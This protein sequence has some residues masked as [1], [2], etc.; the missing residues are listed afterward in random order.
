[1]HHRRWRITGI[2]LAALLLSLPATSAQGATARSAAYCSGGGVTY[3]RS[4]DGAVFKS[5]RTARGMNCASAR[6]VMNKWL[7]RA[8]A[9]S[10]S[11]RL[12]GRFYDGYVTWNCYKVTSSRWRCSE[13]TSNTAFTFVA[14]RV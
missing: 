5:L 2:V 14:Y 9:N 3:N 11:S 7:R 4:G 12:P 1:M 13:Y 6:Y 10:Y 8:Y